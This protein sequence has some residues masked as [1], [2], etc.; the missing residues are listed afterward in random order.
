MAPKGKYFITT[1]IYLLPKRLIGG[2]CLSVVSIAKYM[3][4]Q[5]NRRKI[6]TEVTMRQMFEA[7]VHFGHRTRHWNPKMAPYI[8]GARDKIHIINLELTLPL[9]K[10]GINFISGLVGKRGKILFV[11]TKRA[12]REIIKEQAI[13]CG[14]PYVNH[15]WLGGMLT[16]YRTVRQS[17]KRLKELEA[18]SL[19]GTF[20]KI[21]KKEALHLTREL[22]KLERSLGGIADMA[23]LPDALFVIDVGHEHIAVSEAQKLS[24]PIVGIVDTNHSPDGI[25]RIIPGNDDAIRAVEL[26]VTGVADAILHAKSSIS[27]PEVP[28]A[29]REEPVLESATTTATSSKE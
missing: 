29:V 20:Q 25:D 15:R 8:Y 17:I 7:G 4:A 26:Y 11:G 3:E 22:E 5:P 21:P 14:M 24:I 1:H 13:R 27:T 18:M 6:M 10:E 12:A 2:G 19:D 9:Y 16:N 28:A 23:G